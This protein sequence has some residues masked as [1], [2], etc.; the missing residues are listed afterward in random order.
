MEGAARGRRSAQ[1]LTQPAA[2]VGTSPQ[3]GASALALWC[4]RARIGEAAWAPLA[5]HTI[6]VRIVEPVFWDKEGVRQRA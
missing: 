3:L 5:N 2:D 1:A 4:G 6:R